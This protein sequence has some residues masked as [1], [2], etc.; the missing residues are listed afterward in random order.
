[1]KAVIISLNDSYYYNIRTKYIE[2]ILK[3]EGYEVTVLSAD[4]DHRYK[5]KYAKNRD[6]L[7]RLSVPEY[8][9]NISFKRIY[10]HYIF[11]VKVKRFLKKNKFDLIYAIIPPNLILSKLKYIADNEDLIKI[12]EV[13]DMWPESLPISD[14]V[15]KFIYLPLAYWKLLRDRNLGYFDMVITECDKFESYIRKIHPNTRKLYFCKKKNIRNYE[16][17]SKLSLLYL[18]SINNI[19][20]IDKITDICNE[21]KKHREMN[22]HIIGDG[23]KKEF[24]LEKLKLNNIEYIF[25]DKIFDDNKKM[26]VFE[27]C[28]FGLNI[29]KNS[30]Y[31]GMTMKSLDYFSFGLPIINNIDGDTKSLLMDNNIGYNCIENNDFINKLIKLNDVTYSNM[32]NETY[33]VFDENFNVD[34]YK[35]ELRGIIK[36]LKGRKDIL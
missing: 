33:R 8:K 1:M 21:I 28:H 2:H 32:V 18:G 36:F 20:D 11:S 4:F 29:M 3:E 23:E 9:K 15:K 17:K 13:G 27:L 12:C 26:K 34:L 24:F 7:V 35:E 19:I 31:V 22:L 30:V 16:L 25:H 14:K 5:K 6:G 10:S